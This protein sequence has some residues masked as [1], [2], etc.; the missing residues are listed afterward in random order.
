MVYFQMLLGIV[1]QAG[2][3]AHPVFVRL[4]NVEISAALAALPELRI[5]RKFGVRHW[6]E[7][8]FVIHLHHGRSCGDREN[9]S[10]GEE[11]AGQDKCLFLNTF[12]NP[13]AAELMSHYQAGI[14]HEALA[15]PGFNVGETCEFTV[16][17]KGDNGFPGVHFLNDIL[18]TAF[19]NTCTALQRRDVDFL[20]NR[21]GIFGV[22]AVGHCNIDIHL[23]CFSERQPEGTKNP[24]GKTNLDCQLQL[25]WL[26]TVL[27]T[28]QT[29]FRNVEDQYSLRVTGN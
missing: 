23:S 17:S 11:L 19:S 18:R 1:Q 8:E 22:A 6:A 5:V 24:N 4:Q 28:E 20:A 10:L 3:K 25:S 27:K 29:D 13:H 9:L 14:S 7:A 2:A 21:I 26:K 16:I 15:A 12:G